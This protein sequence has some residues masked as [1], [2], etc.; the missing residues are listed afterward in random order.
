MDVRPA[1][2]QCHVQGGRK[3]ALLWPASVISRPSKTRAKSYYFPAHIAATWKQ[4]APVDPTH[5]G[6][7]IRTLLL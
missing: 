2:V 5:S 4:T 3:V 7:H 6:R 1:W